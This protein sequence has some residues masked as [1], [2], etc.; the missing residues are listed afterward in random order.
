MRWIFNKFIWIIGL[1]SAFLGVF[2]IPSDIFELQNAIRIWGNFFTI[3]NREIIFAILFLLCFGRLLYLDFR[4]SIN[5]NDWPPVRKKII[6]FFHIMFSRDVRIAQFKRIA[7]D[8]TLVALRKAVLAARV[9]QESNWGPIKYIS[10]PSAESIEE[11]GEVGIM[12]D[13]G[14]DWDLAYPR[15]EGII[16]NLFDL[17]NFPPTELGIIRRSEAL[18][19]I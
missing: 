6:T 7:D 12:N 13:F 9:L 4:R 16:E 18:I 17:I 15:P 1:L 19:Q 10:L 3:S 2:L 8:E 5:D 14:Y 11:Y